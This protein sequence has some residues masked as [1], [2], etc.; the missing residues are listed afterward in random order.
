MEKAMAFVAPHLLVRFGSEDENIAFL[1]DQELEAR[2]RS[3]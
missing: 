1:A 3:T 2:W